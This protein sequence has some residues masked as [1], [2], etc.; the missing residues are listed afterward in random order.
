[1]P[2]LDIEYVRVSDDRHKHINRLI[3]FR[4]FIPVMF[5][6]NVGGWFGRNTTVVGSHFYSYWIDDY[7]MFRP[8]SAIFR[9]N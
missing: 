9:S 6:V 5:Y 1:M 7:Y 8:C 4:F 3:S 2:R